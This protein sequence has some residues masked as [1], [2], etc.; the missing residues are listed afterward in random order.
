MCSAEVSRHGLRVVQDS[1]GLCFN[2]S[3]RSNILES[4]LLC[5]K[6]WWHRRIS[7]CLPSIEQSGKCYVDH[8]EDIWLYSLGR[9][10]YPMVPGRS[11]V[12]VSWQWKSY[13]CAAKEQCHY[14]CDQGHQRLFKPR[15]YRSPEHG[16]P[17]WSN[18]CWSLRKSLVWIA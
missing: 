16:K 7:S 6:C 1:F 5:A 8:A 14:H 18:H 2:N 13:P 11:T 10:L 3:W 4:R 15:D 9:S 12:H 17:L